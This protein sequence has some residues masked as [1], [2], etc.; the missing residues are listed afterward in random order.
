MSTPMVT[1]AETL[2]R[3]LTFHRAN[4]LP[5]AEELYRHVLEREP[6][7]VDAQHLLGLLELQRGRPAT[8]ITWIASAIAALGAAGARPQP[9]HAALH[10]NLGNAFQA[11]GRSDEAAASYRRAIDLD[12]ACAQAHSNLGNLR[13]TSGDLEA[14]V[15]S[16]QAAL[17]A[18][19]AFPEAHYNLGNALAAMRR[20]EE[21]IASYRKALELRP[22]Y[23]AALH[24]LAGSL[25]TVGRLEEAIANYEAAIKLAP[26]TARMLVSLGTALR[27]AGRLDDAIEQYRQA[28]T[29]DPNDAAAHYNLANARYADGAVEA[30]EA[31]YRQAIALKPDYAEAHFNLGKLTADRGEID[32]AA[33]HYRDALAIDPG[34]KGALFNL[35]NL[36]QDHDRAEEAIDLWQRLIARDRAY[37]EAHA[38]LG[39][40]QHKLG[41]LKPALVAFEH[42]LALRPDLAEVHYNY[43]NVLEDDDQLAAALVHYQRAVELRP[44]YVE[45]HWNR[46]LALLRAGDFATGWPEYEWRWRRPYSAP[47]RRRFVQPQWRG[48]P[49]DGRRILLHAEQGL[50]D[51]LQFCRYAPLVAAR[52]AAAVILEV[53]APLL[54][55]MR[56]SLGG[57]GIEIVPMDPGFPGGD[58]LPDFDLHCP[59]M[60][61][62]LAFGTTL[63]SIPAPSAYLRA[64]PGKLSAWQDRVA[65][66][67][68]PRVGLVWAGGIRPNDPQAVATDRRRSIAL[69]AL[70]PLAGMPGV[71]W[72]SLQ[73]GPPAAQAQDPPVGLRLID[74]MD[75][76]GDFADTAALIMQLDLVISVDTSVAH[77][78]A[79]LGK[80]VWVLSRFDGCWRWLTGRDDS[81]W[82]PTLRLYRQTSPGTWAPVIARLRRDL[83]TWV[84]EAAVAVRPP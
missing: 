23:P 42:A 34:M 6:D 49:L 22:A 40:A 58:D 16:Y 4:R 24:N 65:G 72:F 10:L 32:Q 2:Q 66:H 19:P 75:A 48:E 17:R 14:A 20:D 51:T 56:D 52:D 5:E 55:V 59:L 71:T 44:N 83:E 28:L 60:S 12:P 43:A 62:P 57:M 27:E 36:L 47:L 39:G 37:A 1:T 9:A 68:R 81:P 74:P 61:L 84:A 15:A 31:G 29:L 82:Y 77:L 26:R 70:A 8:A 45:A 80:P 41:R 76:V 50:G 13:Q 64:D 21:A 35:A 73:K 25:Q 33:A 11:A 30:A 38:G 63:D 69:A 67:K 78:A 54:A 79:G 46:S 18:D 7:H 3:A 53:P